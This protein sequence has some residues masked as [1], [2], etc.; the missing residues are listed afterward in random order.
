[1][2]ANHKAVLVPGLW[3]FRT[4]FYGPAASCCCV[5][6]SGCP[7]PVSPACWT[8]CRFTLRA[9]RAQARPAPP[10]GATQTSR[11]PAHARNTRGCRALSRRWTR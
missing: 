8:A 10:I 4:L 1:M 6:G 2:H 11:P 3:T 7:Q 9:Q 5:C